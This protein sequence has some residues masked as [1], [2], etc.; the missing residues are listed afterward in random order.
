MYLPYAGPADENPA[1]LSEYLSDV[2]CRLKRT[3]PVPSLFLSEQVSCRF[4]LTPPNRERHLR[5]R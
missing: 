5:H 1:H 3:L 2:S 4:V